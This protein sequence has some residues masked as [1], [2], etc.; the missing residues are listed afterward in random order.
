MRALLI[1]VLL[2]LSPLASAKEYISF[3]G[4]ALEQRYLPQVAPACAAGGICFDV[5]YRWTI[6]IEKVL[7]GRITGR[8]VRAARIQHTE[9]VD[10]HFHQ[11][12]Y[13]LSRIEDEKKRKLVGAD[14][15]LEEYVAPQTVYCLDSNSYGIPKSASFAVLAG[16]QNCY[17][18]GTF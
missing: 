2:L 16:T 6:R 3:L 1:F 18:K 8:I 11:A 4:Q 14:Y 17:I 7:S 10:A 13:V 5:V 12:L 15:W 9:Y